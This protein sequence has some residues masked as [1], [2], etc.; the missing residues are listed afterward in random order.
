MKHPKLTELYPP[1]P[2]YRRRQPWLGRYSFSRGEWR[3]CWREARLLRRRGKLVD[4]REH[5]VLMVAGYC[6][7]RR[8]ST[9]QLTIPGIDRLYTKRLVA[10]I[11][12]E[13]KARGR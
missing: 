6:L 4:H 1:G 7:I 11:V 13:E 10:E 8:E 5:G 9:D 12:A 2:I 3:A